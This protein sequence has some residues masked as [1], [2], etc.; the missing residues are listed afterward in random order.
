M[1]DRC[2]ESFIWRHLS[3]QESK[4]VVTLIL[5]KVRDMNLNLNYQR[6]TKEQEDKCNYT[7]KKAEIIGGF[8][9]SFLKAFTDVLTVDELLA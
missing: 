8:L 3:F 6:K 1:E 7:Y 5:A 9:N 2:G 4:Q